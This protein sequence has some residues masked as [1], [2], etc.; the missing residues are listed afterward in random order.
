MVFDRKKVIIHLQKNQFRAVLVDPNSEEGIDQE[1]TSKWDSQS[2]PAVF[3]QV[4]ETFQKKRFRLLVD[5]ALSY[6][7]GV[8]VPVSITKK[9]SPTRLQVRQ[10]AEKIIPEDPKDLV[11]DWVLV[12]STKK[13]HY[14]QVFALSK[15]DVDVIS[16]AAA[17][18]EVSIEAVEALPYSLSGEFVNRET[19]F[20]LIYFNSFITLSL[21]RGS[22]V[23]FSTETGKSDLG[24][25]LQN[26][27]IELQSFGR[28]SFKL[29][30]KEVLL[31]GNVPTDAQKVLQGVFGQKIT[32]EVVNVD[33]VKALAQKTDL[34]GRDEDVLNIK[35]VG[36]QKKTI[37]EKEEVLEKTLSKPQNNNTSE[38]PTFA[39]R[40]EGFK[41]P[42]KRIVFSILAVLLVA[43]LGVS[44]FLAFKFLAPAQ[45]PKPFEVAKPVE[46]EPAIPVTSL[47]VFVE[48]NEDFADSV[49]QL[50]QFL[51]SMNYANITTGLVEGTYTVSSVYI[52]EKYADLLP[53]ILK[54]LS[55]A[56][57]VAS[58]SATLEDVYSADI[59]I[60]FAGEF[61]EEVSNID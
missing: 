52:K 45:P 8:E 46:V 13:V 38:A 21:C 55:S 36:K 6:L 34:E 40:A 49:D 59:L 9:K 2:L 18:A 14:V 58:A 16:S 37:K 47:S 1:F 5:S 29:D 48:A 60:E 39:Q 7:V 15:E 53:N 57:E 26:S 19:P 4:K 54:D 30:V 12:K 43:A 24:K 61:V 31:V 11:W 42:G 20:I 56:V 35:I 33:P 25:A 3:F 28:S 27:I 10:E 41:S 50:K 23:L 22:Q 17:M 32:V 44:G 51:E